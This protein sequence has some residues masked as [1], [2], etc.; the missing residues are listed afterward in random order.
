MSLKNLSH[1]TAFNAPL[2]LSR[3]EL[4]F[5]S[6]ASWVEKTESGSKVE[7]GVKVGLLILMIVTIP[8]EKTILVNSLLSK[9]LMVL[10]MISQIIN[11]W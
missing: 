7:K 1:F 6:A 3:K 4:R 9:Y 2:F 10:W 11:L 5:I 8:T